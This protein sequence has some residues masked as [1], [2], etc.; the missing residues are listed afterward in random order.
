MYHSFG[1]ASG[2]TGAD[3][4][5][6]SFFTSVDSL[7][8]RRAA[9]RCRLK[10][11]YETIRLF[12]AECPIPDIMRLE[13]VTWCVAFGIFPCKPLLAQTEPFHN[14]AV[15]IRVSP[16]EIVQESPALVDHHD[17]SPPRSMVLYVALK[18]RSQ[19]VDPLAQQC[20]LHLR[21]ARILNM[22]TEL[23]DQRC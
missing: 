14:L 4:S 5:A 10:L 18:V 12:P 7:L 1:P 20:N 17:Q 22:L 13:F 11:H 9:G 21:L 6:F 15:P 23:F 2:G 8:C 16:V 3:P 19:I